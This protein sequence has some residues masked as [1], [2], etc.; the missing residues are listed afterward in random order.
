M[1]TSAQPRPRR[2]RRALAALAIAG[3]AIGTA[4]AFLMQWVLNTAPDLAWRAGNAAIL[5]V[6]FLPP[7]GLLFLL[8]IGWGV[9]A[10]LLTYLIARRRTSVRAGVGAAVA[11]PWI[12]AIPVAGVLIASSAFTFDPTGALGDSPVLFGVGWAG[13]CA[14]LGTVAFLGVLVS[15]LARPS[16]AITPR[17]TVDP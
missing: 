10:A 9:T 13:L 3:A 6:T 17:D 2:P 12:V 8:A 15:P 5:D 14:M 7:G 11:G 1:T 16:F 4:V